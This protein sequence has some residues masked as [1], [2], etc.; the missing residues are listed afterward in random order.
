M[1]LLFIE[2]FAGSFSTSTPGWESAT[3]YPLPGRTL[4]CLTTSLLLAGC[5]L[6]ARCPGMYFTAAFQPCHFQG[7]RQVS[8]ITS[9]SH[10][11]EGYV[12]KGPR[13]SGQKQARNGDVTE[14]WLLER[15]QCGGSH[16]IGA[17]QLARPQI[18]PVHYPMSN[19]RYPRNS[20][21]TGQTHS[22]P[23]PEHS[24]CSQQSATQEL[25][26]WELCVCL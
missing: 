2:V 21:R 20:I 11:V 13:G 14:F 16:S 8:S 19:N 24:P 10:Y 12:W 1:S 3:F 25:S 9:C 7:T 22:N 18:K 23:S 5:A 17:K 4:C 6:T 26:M 15:W